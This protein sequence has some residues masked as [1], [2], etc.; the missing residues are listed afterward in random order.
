MREEYLNTRKNNQIHL[1]LAYGFYVETKHKDRK[2]PIEMFEHIL[3]IWIQHFQ[4][5][6]ERYYQH[7]DMKFNITKL[8]M[9]NG[10]IKFI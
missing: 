9:K 10:E 1:G 2:I 4:P 8:T 6:M 7:F 3:T 5:T